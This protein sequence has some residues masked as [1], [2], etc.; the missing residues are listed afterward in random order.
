MK[1]LTQ[2]FPYFHAIDLVEWVEMRRK[3]KLVGREGV[4]NWKKPEGNFDCLKLIEK[5]ER[6]NGVDFWA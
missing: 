6:K 3:G 4:L 2:S 5:W 1:R